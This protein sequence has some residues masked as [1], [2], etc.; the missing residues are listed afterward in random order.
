MA[1]RQPRKAEHRIEFREFAGRSASRR[2]SVFI[3]RATSSISA[4]YAAGTRAAADRAAGSWTGRPFM[5]SNSSTKSARLH[6]QQFRQRGAALLFVLGENHLAHCADSVSSKNM[7]SVRQRPMPSPPNLMA[8][9]ASSGRIG[10]DAEPRACETEIGPAHQRAE[11]ARQFR[12]DHSASAGQHLAQRSVDGDD[13]AGLEGARAD[14]HGAAAVVDADAA[15]AGDTGLAMAACDHRGVRGHAAR[16]VECLQRRACRECLLGWFSIRTR[17]TLR[18]SACSLAA[19]S[20][21]NTISPRRRPAT[22]AGRW[23]SHR[24][25]S[26][27][28]RWSGAA[29]DRAMRGRIRDTASFF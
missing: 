14:A 19:S 2:G 27:R 29:I 4:W 26:L 10:I 18:P 17:T 11:F 7:C 12:L 16:V 1:R 5:I 9:R 25:S 13:V 21:E 22:P 8:V 3:A 15:A 28:D 20:E 6:R 24:V 23:R